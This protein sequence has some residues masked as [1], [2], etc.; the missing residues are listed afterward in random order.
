M[1]ATVTKAGPYHSSGSISFSSLRTNFKESGSGSVSASELRRNTSTTD[2]NPIVPDAVENASVSTSSNLRISQFRNTIKYYY[3]TQTETDTNFNISSQTWNGNLN[4]NIRKWLYV[5]GIIGSYSSSSA[6]ASLDSTAYNLTID[7]SG[8]IYGAAGDS[9]VSPT[10]SGGTGGNA[11]SI[12]NSSGSNLVVNLQSTAKIYAGG[13]GGEKGVT[14]ANGANGRC[15]LYDQYQYC[16]PSTNTVCN[17]GTYQ[18]TYRVQCCEG[19]DNACR[20]S[21]WR[22]VCVYYI[23]TT[24][25]TGGAGGNGGIGRGF[26]NIDGTLNGYPGG[27]GGDP[28]AAGYSLSSINYFWSEN[29]DDA[30][31]NIGGSGSARITVEIYTNDNPGSNGTAYG[32]IRVRDGSTA[33]DPEI[34]RWDFSNGYRRQTFIVTPKTYMFQVGSN[35]RPVQVVSTANPPYVKLRDNSGDDANAIIY[36]VSVE[37]LTQSYSGR[38]CGA[39]SGSNG[40]SGGS[41]GEWGAS[42]G[43][44]TNTGNGGSPGKAITGTGYSV[45]GTIN[46]NTIKGT[47]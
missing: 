45:T 12:A 31:L 34:F 1:T 16:L 35:P 18:Y 25:G 30:F 37:Q 27:V 14:G 47:R 39:T 9:G 10:V 23:N 40:E 26:N 15:T 33:S 8:S 28:V 32:A 41:G 44:T 19:S 22:N 3:I 6:A 43:N 11:L 29:G 13:G 7:V 21:V 4:K 20:A 38:T 46:T 17:R 36:V 2:T 5:Q 24:G 42:G